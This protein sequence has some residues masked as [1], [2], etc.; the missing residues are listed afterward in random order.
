MSY[1]YNYFLNSPA[2]KIWN[3]IGTKRRSGVVVPLFSIYSKESIGIGELPDLKLIT[4]WCVKT[5][6]SIIQ[7]LPL[8]ESSGYYSPYSSISTFAIEPMFLRLT[9]LK[10][11]DSNKY[12]REINRLKSKY[13][14]NSK[15]VDYRIKDDKMALLGK[16]Y[17]KAYTES[18]EFKNFIKEN[19]YWLS[20]YA[21]FKI[22]KETNGN[23][24]WEKWKSSHSKH[25]KNLLSKLKRK[26]SRRINFFYWIQWQLYE[27]LKEVKEYANSLNVLIMGDIP[28]LVSKDSA[29]VWS[30]QK[31]FKLDK[32]AG[33]PP[34]MF[35]AFG[36]QWG[37]P[38]YNWE[39][40]EKNKFS[41]I[42][43]RL[44]Y[45]ENFYD[46]YRIDHFV[47]LF[48]I[49]TFENSENQNE[50][51]S[52]P[53]PAGYDPPRRNKWEQHGKKIIRA[54]LKFS[55]MLPCAEDLG[56]VP[57]GSF[58]TLRKYKLPGIDF[59]RYY[60][61]P[62]KKNIFVTAD[63][64]RKNSSAVI[65][66]H[67]TSFF[68]LW[69][70]YEAGKIDEDF[71]KYLCRKNNII[72]KQYKEIKK[73]LFN[74]KLSGSGKLLWNNEIKNVKTL[75]RILKLRRD[76]D[77][78]LVN[79]YKSSFKEKEKFMKYLFGKDMKPK[80]SSPLFQKKC[81]EVI[82][83]SKSIFSVQLIQEYLFIEKKLFDVMNKKDYRINKPG[84]SDNK[85][86]AIRIPLYVEQLV[87]SP[88]YKGLNKQILNINEVSKRI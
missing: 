27:Q 87:S 49:W 86:W 30:H 42:K 54:M 57:S 5:G 63:E 56:T 76:D 84:I 73:K 48:R 65:S 74:L 58:V 24:I 37:M 35:F 11:I 3:R 47:G 85:N 71:F 33:A 38:P 20:N 25:N 43:E 41:Y 29:D 64:Y 75:T 67:D 60:K 14:S 8:N 31:Y 2:K 62:R 50:R 82:G 68:P 18:S 55:T 17:K 40:I 83:K 78:K 46:M 7:L 52:G 70:R 26:Y 1:N 44:K 51:G 66:T 53:I 69:W 4:D 72:G 61:H 13:S 16:M 81:L 12:K 10:G 88:R 23:K 79:L 80:K 9:D 6:I 15:R 39:K 45:A 22:L 34:D 36:Q 21:M 77:R 32:S 19:K 59:Q 28:F